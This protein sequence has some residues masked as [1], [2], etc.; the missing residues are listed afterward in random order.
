[1]F[2]VHYE[3]RQM[4]TRRGRA[5]FLFVL[6]PI[7]F[8]YRS[9]P[10]LS[11]VMGKNYGTKKRDWHIVHARIESSSF[12]N[13][14]THTHTHQHLHF[15]F[16]PFFFCFI[17]SSSLFWLDTLAPLAAKRG[18]TG[19]SPCES[20]MCR[21]AAQSERFKKIRRKKKEERVGRRKKKRSLWL[22]ILH[23]L[24]CAIAGGGGMRRGGERVTVGLG[25]V[26]FPTY[27]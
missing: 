23:G 15:S 16:P 22:H 10:L 11:P 14:C 20:S 8:F 25:K 18:G 26:R 1:M 19:S 4:Y 2:Y 13:L 9:F 24:T 27:A 7:F 17:I 12:K 3:H 21:S 5:S 6:V